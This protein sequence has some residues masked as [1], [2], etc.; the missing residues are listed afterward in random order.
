MLVLVVNI[1][2]EQFKENLFRERDF[3]FGYVILNNKSEADQFENQF[4]NSILNGMVGNLK[5]SRGIIIV[6]KLFIYILQKYLQDL[7]TI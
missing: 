2:I 6:E 1:Q 3:V 7:Q 5:I 4:K